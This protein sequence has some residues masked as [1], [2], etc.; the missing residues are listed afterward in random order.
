MGLKKFFLQ[1]PLKSQLSISLT[2]LLLLT[3]LLI[4]IFSEAIMLEYQKY[5]FTTRKNY[6]FSIE[7]NI[8][9]SKIFFVNL[10]LFEYDFLIKLFNYQ[11]YLYLKNKTVLM[12]FAL[13]NNKIFDDNRI[14]DYDPAI[15]QISEYNSNI[16]DKDQK[17]YLYCYTKNITIRNMVHFLVKSNYL[18]YLYQMEGIINFRIPFYG[19]IPL[20]EEYIIF[21]NKYSTL[22]ST[23]NT[24]IK[25]IY[26]QSNGKIAQILEEKIELNYNYYKKYFEMF[27]N[28]EMYFFDIMYKLRYYIFSNYL[29][30]KDEKYKEEYIKQQSIF[31]QA[32]YFETDSSRF[33]DTWNS[34][35]SRGIGK[36][37]IIIGYIDFLFLHLS[38]M[39]N[40]YTIPFD[41]DENF[42]ISKNLCYFF[43]YK[44]LVYMNI[45][46]ENKDINFNKNDLDEIYKS[47]Y[48]KEV[49]IDINDCKLEKY[50][51]KNRGSQMN[52]SKQ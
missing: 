47:L 43:L 39:V 32:N 14:V 8:L 26:D 7:Q 3:F 51:S 22:Y 52:V 34:R 35:N 10:C 23:N 2:L 20:L 12:Q 1:L 44:Q 6:F 48:D 13:K 28:N 4:I 45:T 21:F 5:L 17:I 19:D 30:L 29:E 46:S 15:N 18:S 16:S 38:S 9:E 50:Y 31:F 36:N 42:L 11:L 24:R 27:E 49:I 41:H 25:E 33:Y 37:N 40:L